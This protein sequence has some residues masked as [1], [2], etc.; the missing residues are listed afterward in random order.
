GVDP[1]ACRASERKG[2]P[3]AHSPAEGGE[4]CGTQRPHLAPEI[5]AAKWWGWPLRRVAPA[6]TTRHRIQTDP[7]DGDRDPA[8]RSG[9]A[10][11]GSRRLA[12]RKLREPPAG[13]PRAPTRLGAR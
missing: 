5:T 3:P 9:G 10:G 6:T 12:R 4:P 8:S 2:A 1:L 7:L 13:P 11:V